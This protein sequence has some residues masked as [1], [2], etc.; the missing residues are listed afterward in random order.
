MARWRLCFYANVL[1]DDVIRWLCACVADL[2]FK[3]KKHAGYD[4]SDH[5]INIILLRCYSTGLASLDLFYTIIRPIIIIY[6][7]Q[8]QID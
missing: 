4:A 3:A 6:N 7:V 8:Q 1:V 5:L 2:F